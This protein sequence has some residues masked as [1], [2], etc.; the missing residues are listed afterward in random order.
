MIQYAGKYTDKLSE[1]RSSDFKGKY[2]TYDHKTKKL[3]LD[4]EWRMLEEKLDEIFQEHGKGGKAV[5]RAIWEVNVK[6]DKKWDNYYMI[7]TLAERLG[8]EK[9]W[10]KILSSLEIIGLIQRHKG[11]IWIPEEL[12]PLADRITPTWQY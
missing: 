4:S 6:L 5:L 8:L 10:F 3:K 11:D 7:K 2:Y 1:S 12:L 9:G